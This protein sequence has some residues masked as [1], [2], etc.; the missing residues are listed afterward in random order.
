MA[1]SIDVVVPVHGGWEL[2]HR[3]LETLSVQTVSH[4]VCVVD[5]ASPDDTAR[6]VREEWSGVDLVP[7]GANRGY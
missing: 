1:P 2:T 7:M 3:C 5:N 4:R 6:R